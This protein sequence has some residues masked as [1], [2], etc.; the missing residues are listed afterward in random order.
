M[1]PLYWSVKRVYGREIALALNRV[2]YIHIN[3][4]KRRFCGR[5]TPVMMVAYSGTPLLLQLARKSIKHNGR[6]RERKG[7]AR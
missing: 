6:N 7:G 5:Q 3:E 1:I 2:R 4:K